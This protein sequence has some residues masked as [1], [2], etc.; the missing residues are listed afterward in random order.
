MS[1]CHAVCSRVESDAQMSWLD[2]IKDRKTTF[3]MRPDDQRM[4]QASS[5]A[6]LRPSCDCLATASEDYV[7]GH[8][9]YTFVSAPRL[10]EDVQD[11]ESEGWKVLLK[12][13]NK[14]AASSAKVFSPGL[15]MSP[16]LWSQIVELPPTISRL[17][18]VRRMY[19]C[20]SHLVRV[21]PEIGDMAKLE[22]FDAYTS[23]RLHW[24][25]Y[26]ITRCRN[27]KQSRVSTRALYGNYKYRPPFPKI[28]EPVPSPNQ[29]L[30][31]AG[32][33]GMCSVCAQSYS[34]SELRQVW[35]SLRV[36]TDV[37]PLLVNACSASCVSKLP[38]PANGYVDHPHT[39]GVDLKQ[40]PAR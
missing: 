33:L 12:L 16:E 26:E 15:E 28:V 3:S 37:L 30:A 32:T 4:W 21:P 36:A 19:L 22:E 39:G 20:G 5:N 40:P 6:N 11:T 23:Y 1:A 29:R 17:R 8:F 24:L 34:D 35:I 27:L 9:V 38:P 13:I 10:H 14:A 18:H 2:F 7:D 31:F 25:P